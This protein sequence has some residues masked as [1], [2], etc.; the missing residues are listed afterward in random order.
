MTSE[1]AAAATAHEML[2]TNETIERITEVAVV[3]A[4]GALLTVTGVPIAIAWLAPTLFLVIRPLAVW[5]G[6]WRSG[7]TRPQMAI[8]AWFG[9]RGVGSVYYLAYAITH[10]LDDSMA[11]SLAALTLSLIGVSIVVHGFSVTPLMD[12]YERRAA[13]PA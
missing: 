9:I 4:V 2:Q 10:G 3:I 6:L 12:W 5:L 1:T 11:S 13:R 8:C 7:L